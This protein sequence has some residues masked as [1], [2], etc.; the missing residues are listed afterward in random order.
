MKSFSMSKVNIDMDPYE[1][2]FCKKE[3]AHVTFL[4]DAREI[5]ICKNCFLNAK[6]LRI[7][8]GIKR[9]R[10]AKITTLSLK[11]QRE[12]LGSFENRILGGKNGPKSN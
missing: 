12:K 7:L 3:L 8:D 5:A 4:F 10:T 11:L 9:G 1:C 2:D 6:G